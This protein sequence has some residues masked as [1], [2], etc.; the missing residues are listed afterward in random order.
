MLSLESGLYLRIQE[1]V[2]GPTPLP[3]QS[4]F[5]NDIAYRALGMFHAAESSDAH[6]LLS[7]DKDE[8]CAIRSGHLRTV[9]LLPHI[10]EIRLPLVAVLPQPVSGPHEGQS[11]LD[12]D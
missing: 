10:N 3:L 5:S 11:R 2:H 1:M 4:G 8:I 7:N 12:L 6:F 9:A